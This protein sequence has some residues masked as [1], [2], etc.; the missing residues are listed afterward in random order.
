MLSVNAR[1]SSLHV[2]RWMWSIHDSGYTGHVVDIMWSKGSQ[3]MWLMVLRED[4]IVYVLPV[5][6]QTFCGGSRTRLN[7]IS[8]NPSSVFFFC[9]STLQQFLE[10]AQHPLFLSCSPPDAPSSLFWSKPLNK[11]ATIPF[12]LRRVYTFIHILYS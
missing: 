3:Y 5:T 11:T 6:C 1:E 10:P 4:E 7:C 8:P 2:Y 12:S 9:D